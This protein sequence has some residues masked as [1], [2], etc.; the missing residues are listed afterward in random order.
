MW[1]IVNLKGEKLGREKFL[2][3]FESLLE[4]GIVYLILK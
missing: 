1:E 4:W 3:S 2:H